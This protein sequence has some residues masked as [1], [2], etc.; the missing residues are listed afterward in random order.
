MHCGGICV[1]LPV[2]GRVWSSLWMRKPCS[3]PSRK[4]AP[5]RLLCA[6][7]SCASPPCSLL[8]VCCSSSSTSHPRIIR[9]TRRLGGLY[10]AGA[11]ARVALL[12]QR[13]SCLLPAQ[14]A[15]ARTMPAYRSAELSALCSVV[16]AL[17]T[18]FGNFTHLLSDCAPA[19]LRRF[20]AVSVITVG[21]LGSALPRQRI[22]TVQLLL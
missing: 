16:T 5:R 12:D 13:N 20:P 19:L 4:V 2:T 6:A 8:A 10:G 3:A 9:R 17:P 1:L 14:S 18:P 7:R 15:S 21:H 22:S 11:P